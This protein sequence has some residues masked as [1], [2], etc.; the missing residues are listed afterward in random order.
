MSANISF[1][2]YSPGHKAA[3]LALFDA[4]CPEYFS[5]G[6]RSDYESFL[7]ANSTAYEL[8]FVRGRVAGAF[9]L[10]GNDP[11]QR[12]LNWILL[13]PT[14]QGRGIGAAIMERIILKAKAAM[15]DTISIDAS[16]KSAPFFEKFGAVE[17][18]RTENGWGP[19]LHRVEMTL[20]V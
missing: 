18:N 8:C 3:C 20:Q 15:V 12:S 16:Q 9:G 5:P 17:I 11:T 19:G 7:E 1:I 2:S 4:N 14:S 13:G 6:E 10:M